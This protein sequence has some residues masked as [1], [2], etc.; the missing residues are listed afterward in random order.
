MEHPF[1][2]DSDVNWRLVGHCTKV[3]EIRGSHESRVQ[4]LGFRE[5]K[6]VSL[7]LSRLLDAWCR[8]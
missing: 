3:V 5:E 7:R 1:Q 8:W 6:F 2:A 4:G